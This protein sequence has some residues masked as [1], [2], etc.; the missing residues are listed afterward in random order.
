MPNAPCINARGSGVHSVRPE[1]HPDE[2]QQLSCFLVRSRRGD[3]RDIHAAGLVDLHVVD[4]GKQQLIPQAERVIATAVE[5]TGRDALEIANA[6]QRNRHETIEEFPHPVAAQRDHR[7]DRHALAHLERG[8]RLLGAARDRLLAGDARQLVGTHVHQLGVR[9]RLAEAHVDDHLLDLGD[10]HQVLV[11]ELLGQSRHD[12]LLV[13]LFQPVH[14]S[15]TPSHLRQTR[16]LRPSPRILRPTRVCAP[17]SGHTSCTL[18][19][20]SAA[21][22]WTMPPWMFLPGFGRVWRL[23]MFTP[24]TISRFFSGT[25]CRTRPRF[26]RSL[27]VTTST[28]SFFRIGVAMRDIES[29]IPQSTS[30]ASEMIFMKRRSRSSR[31]TGPNTRVPI[32]SLLSLTRTAALRSKR[33]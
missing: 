16:T 27:P 14:L 12:F 25:I 10:R 26:P 9:R 8:N 17:H 23:I 24:S 11:A 20:W 32:G 7:G 30:G 19:A 6:G 21:S 1:R 33:I 28:V 31:A 22:R 3:D 29:L 4:F 18:D 15:T 2:L 13:L 5:S